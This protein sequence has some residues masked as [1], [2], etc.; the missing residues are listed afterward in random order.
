MILNFKVKQGGFYVNDLSGETKYT[1]KVV[2]DGGLSLTVFDELGVSELLTVQQNGTKYNIS[3]FDSV[4]ATLSKS[5]DNTFLTEVGDISVAGSG[6]KFSVTASTDS[7]EIT[8]D[9]RDVAISLTRANRAI[10]YIAVAVVLW[11]DS[12]Q[13]EKTVRSVEKNT[14]VSSEKTQKSSKNKSGKIPWYKVAVIILDRLVT[15]FG[16]GI[17]KTGTNS[18]NTAKLRGKALLVA[19]LS[20]VISI[21]LA[22]SFCTTTVVLNNRNLNFF[23]SVATVENRLDATSAHYTVNDL[24]YVTEEVPEG[25]RAFDEFTVY[26]SLN[27]DGTVRECRLAEYSVTVYVVLTVVFFILSIIFFILA[28]FGIPV[29]LVKEKIAKQ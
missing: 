22:I 14:V 6:E 28:K 16:R 18:K 21:V 20:S 17:R 19:I 13:N 10:I 15:A 8:F 11:Y 2:T 23:K 7:A 1:A 4:I 26:Y 3:A 24:V 9:N 5:A 12:E 29:S 25:L 27:D